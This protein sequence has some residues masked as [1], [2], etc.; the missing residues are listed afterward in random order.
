MSYAEFTVAL[1][2]LKMASV[3]SGKFRSGN[4]QLIDYK[5]CGVYVLVDKW[6]YEIVTRHTEY[7]KLLI[8]CD[9]L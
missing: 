1:A 5:Q 2:A 6:R 8:T 7:K 3:D 9:R 4:L